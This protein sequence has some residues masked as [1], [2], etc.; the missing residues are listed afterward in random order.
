MKQIPDTSNG[1][2][3][4]K[5]YRVPCVRAGEN[6]YPWWSEPSEWIPVL[7]PKHTD[8][9]I[10]GVPQQHWHIDYRFLGR[11]TF[12]RLMRHE[13]EGLVDA[14]SRQ[15]LRHHRAAQIVM[16]TD[17]RGVPLLSITEPEMRI[18]TCWRGPLQAWPTVAWHAPLEEAM[19]GKSVVNHKCPH[20]G[21]DLRDC[22]VVQGKR[23]CPGH[24]LVFRESGEVVSGAE[25][26]AFREGMKGGA[27]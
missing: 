14:E 27:R 23:L 9:E 15:R 12:A 26:Q 22:P 24:G 8:Q 20:R 18:R 1:C 19:Q 3:I 25:A 6:R 16:E 7:L 17:L 4:G 5:R 11:R 2:T 21:I 13:I 10:I